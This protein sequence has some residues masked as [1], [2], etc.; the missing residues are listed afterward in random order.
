MYDNEIDLIKKSKVAYEE[1]LIDSS[2]YFDRFMEGSF[3]SFF[4]RN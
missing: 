4:E 2:K 3:L 1:V